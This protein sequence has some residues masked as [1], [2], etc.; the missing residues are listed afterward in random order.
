M[1]KALIIFSILGL[2]FTKSA[3]AQSKCPKLEVGPDTY[4]VKAG[5]QAV[6]TVYAASYGGTWQSLERKTFN[7]TVSNGTIEGGQ[8]TN[9]IRVSTTGLLNQ[10]ITATVEVGGLSPDCS[11][12]GSSTIKITAKGTGPAWYDISICLLEKDKLINMPVKYHSGTGDTMVFYKDR[13]IHF[14][15]AYKYQSLYAGAKKWFI[16]SDP[17]KLNNQTYE[18]YGLPR[19]LTVDDIVKA[20]EYNGVPVFYER[21][22]KTVP[23]VIYIPVRI[24]CEFQPYQKMR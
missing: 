6:F 21:G 15:D 20:T 12:T 18:K 10:A 5:D 9:V 7:W 22:I 3:T 8:G 23:E 4:E 14:R 1:V 16:N 19:I 17:I 24:G 2:L 11:N 13:R